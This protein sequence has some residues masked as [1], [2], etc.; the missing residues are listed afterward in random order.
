MAKANFL[1]M[2]LHSGYLILFSPIFFCSIITRL[3]AH[4]LMCD[5]ENYSRALLSRYIKG[6]KCV[7]AKNI[8]LRKK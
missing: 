8:Q 2:K 4:S 1:T 6:W 3:C 7:G 5:V